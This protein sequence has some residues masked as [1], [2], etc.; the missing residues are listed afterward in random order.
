M[1]VPR[2][3][4]NSRGVASPSER[5]DVAER[6]CTVNDCTAKHRARGLCS[7]H[8]NQQRYTSEQRHPRTTVPCTHCGEPCRKDSAQRRRPFCDYQC[9]DLWRLEHPY[10]ERTTYPRSVLPKDHPARWVGDFTRLAW[11]T[12]LCC[13]HTFCHREGQARRQPHGEGAAPRGSNRGPHHTAVPRWLPRPEQSC[14]GALH[15]QQPARCQLDLPSRRLTPGGWPQT[16]VQQ[17]TAG[18]GSR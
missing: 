15:V 12:C 1:M 13:A 7:T 8:Y 9:R 16:F 5:T 14:D 17:R 11:T 18:E 10:R 3:A 2:R 4:V 6:I